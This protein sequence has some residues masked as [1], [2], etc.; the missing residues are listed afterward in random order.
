LRGR[1]IRPHPPPFVSPTQFRTPLRSASLNRVVQT[2]EHVIVTA[3]GIT[4]LG[5]RKL[6]ALTTEN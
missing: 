1:P 2:G 5:E 6:K 3:T 4:R